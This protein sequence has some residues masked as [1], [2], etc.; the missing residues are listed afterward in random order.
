MSKLSLKHPLTIGKATIETLS[1]RDYTTAADYLAFDKRG[2][3]AQN[4]ALIASV[5][6]MDE[7]VV[8]Q[9]RGADYRAASELVA[10]LLADDA[11]ADDGLDSAEKK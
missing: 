3:E 7:A 6:G 10:K 5:A 1:F 2:N 8:L 9:L 4:I 11:A